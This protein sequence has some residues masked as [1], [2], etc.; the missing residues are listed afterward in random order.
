MC[1]KRWHELICQAPSFLVY[2]FPY[3][4][5]TD[6]YGN[7]PLR[8]VARLEPCERYPGVPLH[9]L[10]PTIYAAALFGSALQLDSVAVA[11]TVESASNSK[12]LLMSAYRAAS[13]GKGSVRSVNSAR[14]Q[15]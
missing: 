9:K 11:K 13:P 2:F 12:I 14:L 6:I 8:K 3:L 4:P 7:Q 5:K 10:F 15:L 1:S